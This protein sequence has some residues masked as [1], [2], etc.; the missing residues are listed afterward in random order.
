MARGGMVVHEWAGNGNVS[1]RARTDVLM[2]CRSRLLPRKGNK[3]KQHLT[4][5]TGCE[6]IMRTHPRDSDERRHRL[7]Y[8][9]DQG[10]VL[11]KRTPVRNIGKQVYS[12]NATLGPVGCWVTMLKGPNSLKPQA[13]RVQTT[14]ET[15]RWYPTLTLPILDRP[16]FLFPV[17][18]FDVR[19]PLGT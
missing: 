11:A 3:C 4:I 19:V 13:R 9:D 5:D 1:S 12:I 17:C 7:G 18:S 10:V 2:F 6:S 14:L 15:A 8:R 16:T